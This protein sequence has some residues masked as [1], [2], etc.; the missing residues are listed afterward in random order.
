MLGYFKTQPIIF[1]PSF[2]S[3]ENDLN[4]IAKDAF[5]GNKRR[6]RI[7]QAHKKLSVILTRTLRSLFLC[8]SSETCFSHSECVV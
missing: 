2:R 7:T 4:F 1:G 8:L 3:I 6:H 5:P